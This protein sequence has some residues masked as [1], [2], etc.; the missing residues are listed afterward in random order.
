MK[1]LKKQLFSYDSNGDPVYSVEIAGLSTETKPT[2]GL[3]SGSRFTEVNTGKTYVLD[4]E[5]D[6]PDWTELVVATAEVQSGE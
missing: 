6:S 5:S 1:I 2:A 4:A 3:V